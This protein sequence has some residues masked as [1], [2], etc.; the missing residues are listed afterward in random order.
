MS[1]IGAFNDMMEQFLEELVQTFPEEPAMK[2]YQVSFDMMKMGNKRA[3]MEYFMGNISPHA[4]RI[5]ARDETFFLENT[6]I[7]QDFNIGSIWTDSISVNT[8]SAIWQYM[9]TLYML[10]MTISAVPEETLQEIEKIAK[11]AAGNMKPGSLDT[12]AMLSG[13]QH[14]MSGLGEKKS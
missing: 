11:K 5:M 1:T 8:K 9:Q 12:H 6:E 4:S 13:I 7:V 14:M 2:K 10:G 3:V